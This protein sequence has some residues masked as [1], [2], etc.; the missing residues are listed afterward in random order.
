[1][2]VTH[3]CAVVAEFRCPRCGAE[4]PVTAARTFDPDTHEL[5]LTPVYADLW[6]HLWTH[7]PQAMEPR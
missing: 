5:T 4:V 3:T 7:D 1:M 6:A 2:N